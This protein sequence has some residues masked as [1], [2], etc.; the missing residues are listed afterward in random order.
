VQDFLTF[1]AKKGAIAH[2][3][4]IVIAGFFKN[5]TKIGNND[6]FLHHFW[7]LVI[8]LTMICGQYLAA[9][10]HTCLFQTAKVE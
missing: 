4:C 10:M 2:K 9:P 8:S 1:S 6:V 3:S 7:F 5:R